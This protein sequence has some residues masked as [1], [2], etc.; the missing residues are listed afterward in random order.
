MKRQRLNKKE[1]IKKRIELRH[2]NL[3]SVRKEQKDVKILSQK[4][5][6]P[7]RNGNSKMVDLSKLSGKE[8]TA[9]RVGNYINVEKQI[10]EN[11]LVNVPI[12]KRLIF[13]ITTY[14]RLRFLKETVESWYKTINKEYSWTL[15]V[16]DDGSTDGTCEYLNEI[17]FEGVKII[18]LK[19][20]YRGVHHQTNEI[21]RIASQIEFDIGFKSDDDVL[22]LK[23]GWDNQYINAIEKTG[24]EHLV[25]FDRKWGKKRN[26]VIIPTIKDEFLENY[27]EGKN[28]QGAFWTFTKKVIERVGYFDLKSFNLCGLGHVDYTFRCCRAGFNDI[29]T[30][31]DV[32]NSNE[33]IMLNVNNY[34]TTNHYNQIWNTKEKINKK[35]EVIN[36]NREFIPYNQC[37]RKMNGNSL[38]KKGGYVS[39]DNLINY[40]NI[41]YD[42]I[43]CINL[44]RRKDKWER[45]KKRFN[46]L[47]ILVNRF[48][49]IDGLN[50]SVSERNQY[51]IINSGAIGC[52]LSHYA[53][54]KH[55]KQFNYQKIL[56]LEDDV[57]FIENFHQKFNEFIKNF[58]N[59]NLLYLGC[60]QHVWSNI[61]F[62]GD[63]YESKECDGTF[64]YSID[65]LIYDDI[66]LTNKI[67]SKP[68]DLILHNIQ[69][70]YN[71]TCFTAFPNLIISDVSDSDIR[72]RRDNNLH[73]VKMKWNLAKYV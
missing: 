32:I 1:I 52:I 65:D 40:I 43:Y 4:T 21:L 22:F 34:Y 3:I 49:A 55:A 25:F 16:A 72:G 61:K 13:A 23:E 39:E 24:Y 47:N 56:I 31:F 63:Y 28:I 53:V 69:R 54:I 64:A 19:N 71:G 62:F 14:N 48:S 58:N 5:I 45:V 51:K 44:D 8:R 66:L 36:E 11:N 18:L 30:P 26:E 7:I 9:L 12:K 70:K 73:R 6:N 68:I 37:K 60:S 41:Y 15:I 17:K 46:D 59:W 33:Y 27:V 35:K 57:L 42:Q 50:L 38:H 29:K 2:K 10:V 67:K 20:D